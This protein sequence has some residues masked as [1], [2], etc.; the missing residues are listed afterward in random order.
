MSEILT[1]TILKGIGGFYY[2]LTADG[3]THTLR[4]QSK[5]RREHLKPMVGDRVEFEAGTDEGWLVKILERKN[6]LLRPPV[7]NI[8][9]AVLTMSASVPPADTLLI[10]RLLLFS[11]QKGIDACVVIN[12]S[13]TDGENA[14][15]LAEQYGKCGA[16]VFC[17][18]AESGEG[19]AELRQ[20]LRGKIH[21]FAGQSGV[22]K[23][24]LINALYGTQLET[25]VISARIERGK[26]TTR[27]CCLIPVEG[28]GGVLDTPGFSLYES[29][30]VQPEKLQEYYEEFR[31]YAE[32]RFSPCCHV[33]EPDC[34]VKKALRE[35]LIPAE[36][37]ERYKL[38]LDEMKERWKQRYD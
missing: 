38:L 19:I 8:D 7:A 15:V 27:S 13:E 11:R 4:A 17:V 14:R 21:A 22:G 30:L 20:Y 18:S 28:G 34:G 24:S 9:E 16:R 29:E 25:G 6:S 12:K 26:N 3:V 33:S 37:Y 36:R 31:P 10:D 5:L 1:G 35:G 23:S 32:C 2:V